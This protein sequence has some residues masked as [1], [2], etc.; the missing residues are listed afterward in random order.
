MAA[1]DRG[2]DVRVLNTLRFSI[3]LSG[4]NPDLQFRG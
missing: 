1:A 2:H 3:D 4:N